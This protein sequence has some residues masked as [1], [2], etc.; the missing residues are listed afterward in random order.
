MRK[1]T[2]LP[3][4]F[5]LI[6]VG[7]LLLG[8][9]GQK[10]TRE[11]AIPILGVNGAIDAKI[12]AIPRSQGLLASTLVKLRGGSGPRDARYSTQTETENGQVI[13]HGPAAP[14]DL[15]LA[16]C[17]PAAPMTASEVFRGLGAG[18]ANAWGYRYR[19]SDAVFETNC[20]KAAIAATPP[21]SVDQCFLGIEGG[22]FIGQADGF[23]FVDSNGTLDIPAGDPFALFVSSMNVVAPETQ[24]LQRCTKPSPPV[25]GDQFVDSPETCDDGNTTPGDGCSATCQ[26]TAQCGDG[27]DNDGDSLTDCTDPGCHTDGNALNAGSCDQNDNDET[28]TPAC[29][30]GVTDVGEACDDGNTS[31]FDACLGTCTTNACGDGIPERAASISMPGEPCDDGNTTVGDGCSTTCVT[32]T[33][34]NCEWNG[35][36]QSDECTIPLGGGV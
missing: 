14:D 23:V 36:L 25:C 21:Q 4:G 12:V 26:T 33:R 13:I 19:D 28:H 24:R 16:D 7:I 6:V 2:Y 31:N 18:N 27:A 10:Q 11:I 34:Y 8:S 32:E 20:V 30:D 15:H 9:Y 29:G 35:T 17:A 3:I 22:K 5:G 1:A